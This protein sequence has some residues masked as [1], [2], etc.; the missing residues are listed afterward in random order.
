MRGTITSASSG[1]NGDRVAATKRR[2]WTMTELVIPVIILS[3]C[4]CGIIASMAKLYRAINKL[5]NDGIHE[6]LDMAISSDD[7]EKIVKLVL[8]E[9]DKRHE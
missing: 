8:D 1:G 5:I 6:T 2:N 7:I 3:V 9:I 4:I